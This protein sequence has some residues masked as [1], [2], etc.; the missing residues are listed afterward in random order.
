MRWIFVVPILV[1]IATV[2]QGALNASV[3][4]QWGLASTVVANNT[5]ILGLSVVLWALVRYLPGWFPEFFGDR[6]TWMQ[7]EWW[8]AI[9]AICGLVIVGGIPW[10]MDRM[11]A[12]PVMVGIVGAQMVG[13][14]LW[15][16]IVDGAAPSWTRI[17]GA[18]LAVAG[19]ILASWPSGE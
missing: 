14:L 3:S 5:V 19:V 13:G 17:A 10:A 8:W 4:R 11:G 18:G 2:V 1:G 7:F 9:P 12:L 6:G 15:D 16:W